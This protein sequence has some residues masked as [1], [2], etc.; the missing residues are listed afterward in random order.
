MVRLHPAAP[1]RPVFVKNYASALGPQDR[2]SQQ[3]QR[4]QVRVRSAGWEGIA[5]R[6]LFEQLDYLRFARDFFDYFFMVFG[7]KR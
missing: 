7:Q 4:I 2:E 6:D 3:A 5:T 1:V